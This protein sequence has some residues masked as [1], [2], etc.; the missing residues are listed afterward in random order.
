MLQYY[1]NFFMNF[2]LIYIYAMKGVFNLNGNLIVN[3]SLKSDKFTHLA[4]DLIESAWKHN[5]NLKKY[6]NDEILMSTFTKDKVLNSDFSLFFDKDLLLAS[7]FEKNGVRLFNSKKI[8]EICDDKAKT[9]IEFLN[10]NIKMPK[11]IFSPLIFNNKFYPSDK[12]ILTIEKHLKYP[13]VMKNNCGS[14]GNEVYLIN[15]RNE[16][17]EKLDSLKT[18]PH[19]F[20]ELIQESN[21]I[22]LR[23]H[24][25]GNKIL[26][27]I[28]RIS[29]YD[30]RANL[31]LNSSG[32]IYILNEKEE[33][34][35][36]E[37][38]RILPVDFAGIDLLLSKDGPLLC[39]INSNAHY[40][41]FSEIT[42][43]DVSSEI[44]KHIKGNLK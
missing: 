35:I 25:V 4:N 34:F 8:I 10:S 39:E 5:I 27:A 20:Q 15:N 36:K 18:I 14:F 13:L 23:V 38:I 24:V 26:G 30:F 43:I 11:T 2:M 7:F 17:I 32:E 37:I 21:G 41:N 44:F 9:H 1:N 22:D 42:G 12:Y 31:T 28:K 33:K 16:L 3:S 29:K 19:L 40:L 6:D